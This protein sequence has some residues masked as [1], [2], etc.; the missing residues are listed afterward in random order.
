[1]AV[2]PKRPRTIRE[3]WREHADPL[4]ALTAIVAA[5]ADGLVREVFLDPASKERLEIWH[6]GRPQQP[7]EWMRNPPFLL[8]ADELPAYDRAIRRW[9]LTSR[10]SWPALSVFADQYRDGNS[11]SPGRLIAVYS[12]LET[13]ARARHGH[14]DFKRLRK[15]GRVDASVTGCTNDAIQLMGVCRGY[16]AHYKSAGPKYPL[17]TI[18]EAILPSIRKGPR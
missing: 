5:R 12:A 13:Y 3:F 18:E 17:E 16:F 2:D 7:T 9:W 15:Y 10:Q 14:E 6:Q 4:C 8:H 1:V 11:Y